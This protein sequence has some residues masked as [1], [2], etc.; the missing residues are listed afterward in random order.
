MLRTFNCGIGMVA[1]VARRRGRGDRRRAFAQAAGDALRPRRGHGPRKDGQAVATSGALRW[2]P[3]KPAARRRT[4]ILI[5]GRGSN[6]AALLEAARDPAYPGRDRAR[7]CPTAPTRPAWP[8]R[9][10]G[11]RP[12]AV[13]D[14]K[15]FADRE[16]FEAALQAAARG[17]MASISS[18]SPVSCAS[19]RRVHR[20]LGGPP[21]QHPP[22]PSARLPGA[23]HARARPRRRR[24]DPWLHGAF[25]RAGTRRRP[26]HRAG[27]RPGARTTRRI[28][29]GARVLRAEHALYP[30]ALRLVASGDASL[31]D[32]RAVVPK[33][34][35]DGLLV[36][37]DLH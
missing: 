21:D 25:R 5:S 4:A 6:M 15:A 18:A 17:R 9:R 16:S 8:R 19:S 7:R 22:L 26:D 11:R 31:K 1:V 35:Q 29:L 23:A 12:A 27:R 13:V 3:P 10:G 24:E 14:H 32:G 28:L 36:S 30:L 37:P 2:S 33:G 20:A 34:V